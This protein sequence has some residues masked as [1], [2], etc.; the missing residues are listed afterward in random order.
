[1][2]ADRDVLA[3]IENAVDVAGLAWGRAHPVVDLLARAQ[4]EAAEASHRR[5]VE[6]ATEAFLTREQREQW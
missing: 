6:R 5:R 1:M 3:A 2:P 4:R